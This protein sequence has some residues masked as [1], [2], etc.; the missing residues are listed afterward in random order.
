MSLLD[1]SI[2]RKLTGRKLEDIKPPSLEDARARID[3][4]LKSNHPIR[5]LGHGSESEV[6]FTEEDR[7][8]PIH[9]LGFPGEG[10][11][12]FLEHLISQDIQR[13]YGACLLDPSDNGDTAYK[14]LRY[15]AKI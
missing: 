2:Y 15:C 1:K 4:Q 6:D 3:A 7:E 12:K 14:I 11:S 5:A 8:S 10:K 13:G 9:I